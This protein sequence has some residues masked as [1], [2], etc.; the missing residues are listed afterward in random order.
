MLGGNFSE[1]AE[2]GI[3]R[4]VLWVRVGV[5][6]AARFEAMVVG[7]GNVQDTGIPS[8]G[9]ISSAPAG[10]CSGRRR[11]FWEDCGHPPG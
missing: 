6:D 3:A 4:G 11:M 1:D 10:H 7:S 9:Y 5:E 2:P 8:G